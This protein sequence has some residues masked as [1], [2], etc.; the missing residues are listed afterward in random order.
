MAGV[1]RQPLL[2]SRAATPFF[3]LPSQ[4]TLQP[5]ALLAVRQQIQ[6]RQA[7]IRRSRNAN[8]EM[9][10]SVSMQQ[11]QDERPSFMIS[12][13]I[14]ETFVAPPL[15]QYMSQPAMFAKM[16]WWGLKARVSDYVAELSVRLQSKPSF[17][18]GAIFK[19]NRKAIGPMAK[20][21]HYQ[22]LEA[23][24]AGDV[25]TLRRLLTMSHLDEISALIARRPRGQ[26]CTWELLSYKG[27]P[28]IAST[29]VVMIP[30]AMPM[31]IRQVV[32][33]IRSRQRFTWTQDET[34][35]AG[36]NNN[37][38]RRRG[39]AAPTAEPAPPRVVEK[40][41]KENVILVATLN[42]QTWQTHDWRIF[43]F[44]QDTTPES[45]LH[46]HELVLQSSKDGVTRVGG[47]EHR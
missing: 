15:G 7:H 46:E 18:K 38:A 2:R 1:L 41:V 25:R 32:V 13:R 36:A 44:I 45:W 43:G 3:L 34:A 8:A 21:M 9:S 14:P 33:T 11:I 40:D 47:V 17:F 5:G 37:K 26:R 10:P 39:A 23:T 42:R 27:K 19:P 29:K 30:G 22:M 20:N 12:F 28:K 24:A 4:A 31:Y 35:V 16:F 6:T